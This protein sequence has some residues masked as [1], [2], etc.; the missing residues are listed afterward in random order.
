MEQYIYQ[1]PN[2]Y[3][4]STTRFSTCPGCGNQFSGVRN[5]DRLHDDPEVAKQLL[6]ARIFAA[7]ALALVLFGGLLGAIAARTLGHSGSRGFI[8]GCGVLTIGPL[9]VLD[10]SGRLNLLWVLLLASL[11]GGIAGATIARIRHGNRSSG[12]LY[13]FLA[14]IFGPIVFLAKG[15]RKAATISL[16]MMGLLLIYNLVHLIGQEVTIPEQNVNLAEPIRK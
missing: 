6:R 10:I 3:H 1:C 9:A 11:A 13:G 2:C 5:V 14:T 16:I 8:Y 15:L 7:L 12:F 4:R